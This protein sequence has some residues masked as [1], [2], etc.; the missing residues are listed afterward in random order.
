ME[1]NDNL[2]LVSL[3]QQGEK[4]AEETLIQKMR[5]WFGVW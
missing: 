1:Q 5:R 2:Q 3:I 4:S